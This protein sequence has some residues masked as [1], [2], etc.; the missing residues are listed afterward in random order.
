MEAKDVPKAH[1]LLM[2]YLAKFDLYINYDE[3]DFAHWLLPREGVVNSYVVEN[4][5]GEI[6]DF[7][8]F[9]WLP[10]SVMNNPLH[11]TLYAGYSYYNVAT[12]VPLFDLM[13]DVMVYAY[14]SNMDVFNCLDVMDN[15]EV[16]EDLKFGI[17]DGN[18]QYYLYNW[19]TPTIPANKVALVLL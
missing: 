13:R 4:P 6:T 12:S 2:S 15:H 11:K 17:G 9:Y 19:Q 1:A 8:S 3:A 18:L 5:E 14:K 10:S 7:A 16:F